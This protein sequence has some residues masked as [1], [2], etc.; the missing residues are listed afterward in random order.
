MKKVLIFGGIIVAIFVAIG[1]LTSMQNSEKVSEDNPYKKDSL[2]PETVSQLDDPNYQNVILPEDLDSA[3]ENGDDVTVYFYS[4]LCQFCK[5]A[6]PILMPVA[7]SLGVEVQQYNLEEF[8]QGFG[9][10][11]IESTP[12][13]VQF[14]NGKEVARI[15]G[16]QSAVEYENFLNTNSVE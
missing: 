14:K 12:T 8:K 5:Q 16:A 7:D 13:L 6:T 9:D 3:L 10:Y 1:V 4:P 2:H 15:V 11:G